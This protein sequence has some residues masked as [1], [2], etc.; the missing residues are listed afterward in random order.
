MLV[1]KIQSD[2]S[3][4][5]VNKLAAEIKKVMEDP[6]CAIITDYKITVEEL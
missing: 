1:I 4:E 2:V 6:N 5:D 3:E